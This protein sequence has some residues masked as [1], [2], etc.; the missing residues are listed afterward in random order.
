VESDLNRN[1]TVNELL[2][3]LVKIPED[4]LA[5][6]AESNWEDLR[7]IMLDI[8]VVLSCDGSPAHT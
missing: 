8:P 4:I 3:Y 7:P 2:N 5:V 1:E 6:K